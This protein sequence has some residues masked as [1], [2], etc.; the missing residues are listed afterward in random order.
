MKL[1]TKEADNEVKIIIF[2]SVSVGRRIYSDVV[3]SLMGCERESYT[4]DTS[5]FKAAILLRKK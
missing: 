2:C 3:T 1:S 4:V 5:P